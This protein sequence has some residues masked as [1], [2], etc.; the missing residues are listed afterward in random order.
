MDLGNKI[1]KL[2]KM[3]GMSQE[4][5]GYAVNV[6]RQTVSK[7]ELGT[8]TP[9]YTSLKELSRVFEVSIEVLTNNEKELD[10][11]TNTQ[12]TLNEYKSNSNSKN[13]KSKFFIIGII[14]ILVF[15]GAM[16]IVNKNKEEKVEKE[17]TGFLSIFTSVPEKFEEIYNKVFG[18]IDTAT[19]KIEESEK[20]FDQ[21]KEK[22]GKAMFNMQF[23]ETGKQKGLFIENIA[24]NI[25]NSNSK[26]EKQIA[27]TYNGKEIATPEEYKEVT[28]SISKDKEYYISHEYDEEGYINEMIIE[29]IEKEPEVSSMDKKVFNIFYGNPGEKMGMHVKQL[30]SEIEGSNQ[31]NDKQILLMF[32]GK[33]VTAGE[34]FKNV[35]SSIDNMTKYYATYSYD[36]DGYIKTIEF[37]VMN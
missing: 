21:Q 2:R 26:N 32:N 27:L 34:G 33:E 8:T 35:V 24:S 11:E 5:L 30:I 12:S 19:E 16:I 4:E 36:D 25:Q 29:E 22:M 10:D 17:K 3:K 14:I 23:L 37:D 18:I 28:L 15:T 9:D 31:T 7:W 6:T 1:I 20:E 13:S